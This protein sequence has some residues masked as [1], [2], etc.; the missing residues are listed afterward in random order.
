MNRNN[1]CDV[2]LALT[3]IRYEITSQRYQ[4]GLCNQ[5]ANAIMASQSRTTPS[6][7]STH[8]NIS[9]RNDFKLQTICKFSFK[10][11]CKRLVYFRNLQISQGL[12]TPFIWCEVEYVYIHM[13]IYTNLRSRT[14]SYSTSVHPYVKWRG[15]G[16]SA[17]SR[18]RFTTTM[19]PSQAR[20]T[21]VI[22]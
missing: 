1:L 21:M 9:F 7:A 8:E 4:W 22:S 11:N 12:H 5:N 2:K 17:L 20:P 15:C 10:L 18:T 13:Y 16:A 14:C 6:T 3:I 19:A